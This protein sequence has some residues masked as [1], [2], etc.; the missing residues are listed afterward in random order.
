ML[1]W[2]PSFHIGVLMHKIYLFKNKKSAIELSLLQLLEIVLA[3][4]IVMLLIYLSLKLAGFFIGRQEYDSTIN[5]LEE[6]S[7]RINELIKD[8]KDA[9]KQ[10]MVY[11]IADNYILVGFSYD[12][13]GVMRTECTNENIVK[14]RPRLCEAKSCLCI[15]QNFGGITDWEG[16]DFDS[17]TNVVPLKCKTFNDKIV[18]LTPN[19]DSNFGGTQ[20]QWRISNTPSTNYNY[21]VVYGKCGL[22]TSWGVKQIYIYKDTEGDNIFISIIELSDKKIAEELNKFVR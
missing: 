15:Y 19:K 16:K 5:N 17:R 1:R 6:L 11:S 13:K 10:S 21:L 14:S 8:K 18:F 9:S 3:I 12:D 7:K 22:G 4:A 2:L 20:T